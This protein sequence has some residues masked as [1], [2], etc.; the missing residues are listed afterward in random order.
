MSAVDPGKR[1][2]GTARL[3]AR[4][5]I[6][7]G[8]WLIT[9]ASGGLGGALARR[10][11]QRPGSE[12]LRLDRSPDA[13]A[14]VAVGGH[15]QADL[16]TDEGLDRARAAIRDWDPTVLVSCA[17]VA[18]SA[19][20]LETTPEHFD[21]IMA[22]DFR[23]PVELMAEMARRCQDDGRPRFVVNIVSPFRLV[24]VRKQALYCVT[25]AALARAGEALSME[26]DRSLGFTVVDVVPGVFNTGIR[27][28]SE[29]D[30]FVVKAYR[31]IAR[32]PDG[33]ARELLFRLDRGTHRR[34]R[35]IRLGWDGPV[36][37]LGARLLPDD[38]WVPLVNR[39]SGQ[40]IAEDGEAGD[41]GDT[42]DTGEAGEDAHAR[43]AAVAES[44][45]GGRPAGA[46]PA[47]GRPSLDEGDRADRAAPE[48]VG[49]SEAYPPAEVPAPGVSSLDDA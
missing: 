28:V 36:L 20:L 16:T 22:V 17:A 6:G 47:E 11:E 23:A 42:G 13:D 48:P 19:P 14:G 33:V 9:G 21:A 35:T 39:I 8:R 25:K 40:R 43:G 46:G 12:V 30:T 10:V 34:H 29:L 41:A 31:R 26:I 38:V 24:G 15:V 49:L 1:P 7:A 44:G 3:G 18:H 37:E 32:D 4:R 27:P 5:R 45:R 2:R